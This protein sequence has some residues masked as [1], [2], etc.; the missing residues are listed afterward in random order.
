[1]RTLYDGLKAMAI[2]TIHHHGGGTAASVQ[3][4]LFSF[5]NKYFSIFLFI[6]T[7]KKKKN[8][9]NFTKQML[10]FSPNLILV[11]LKITLM[12]GNW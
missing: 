1:M 6:S 10:N 11:K 12:R 7:K 5:I 9:Q 2:V 8:L 4:F 3:K